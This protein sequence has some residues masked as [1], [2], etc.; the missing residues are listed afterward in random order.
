MENQVLVISFGNYETKILVGVNT[1]GRIIPLYTSCFS[2]KG[3]IIN[4]FVKDKEYLIRKLN[5]VFIDIKKTIGNFP[6]EIIYNIPLDNLEIREKKSNMFMLDKISLNKENW[7]KIFRDIQINNILNTKYFCLG[8]KVTTWNVDGIEYHA[9]PYGLNGE[10][11]FNTQ[12]FLMEKKDIN[13]YLELFDELGFRKYNIVT[14]EIV[15]NN[16]LEKN[17]LVE[18][19]IINIGDKKTTIS[20]YYNKSLVKI[21]DYDFGIKKLTSKISEITKVNE[22]E[23]IFMLRNYNY[24]NLI[25][26]DNLDDQ[27]INANEL[28]FSISFRDNIMSFDIFSLKNMDDIIKK[29]IN[30]L[31]HIINDFSL[32]IQK[33]SLDIEELYILS[34][35]NIFKYWIDYLKTSLQ[36]LVSCKVIDNSSNGLFENKFLSLMYSLLY[37]ES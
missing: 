34:V 35:T 7:G 2:S 3:S 4:S 23:A 37:S 11:W 17:K 9:T 28:P 6:T 33:N 20:L 22:E 19:A 5:N 1:K 13:C 14:D 16:A 36:F 15:M 25:K 30:D 26:S 10:L 8:K 29:W 27:G 18:Q 31:V 21:I 24:Y 32:Q 12:F